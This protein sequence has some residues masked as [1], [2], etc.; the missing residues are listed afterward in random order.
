MRETPFATRRGFGDGLPSTHQRDLHGSVHFHDRPPDHYHRRAVDDDCPPMTTTTAPELREFETSQPVP[1][2]MT[3]PSEWRRDEA[4]T[5]ETLIVLTQSGPG[6]ELIVSRERD[7]TVEEWREWL[8][9]HERP[10]RLGASA[11]RDQFR[12]GIRG[13]CPSR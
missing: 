13:G 12:R 1:L 6:N 5:P 11:R 3:I 2:T 9:G 10:G 8:T 4:S 7:M